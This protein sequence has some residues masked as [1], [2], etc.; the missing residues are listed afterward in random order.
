MNLKTTHPSYPMPRHLKSLVRH[1]SKRAMPQHT[2]SV[3]RPGLW[4]D[5]QLLVPRHGHN[6]LK[7]ISRRPTQ[8]KLSGSRSER[9][10]RRLRPTFGY[11]SQD[12]CTRKRNRKKWHRYVLLVIAPCFVPF[13][14]FLGFSVILCQGVS[15]RHNHTSCSWHSA[16]VGTDSMA[17]TTSLQQSVDMVSLALAIC[18]DSDSFPLNSDYEHG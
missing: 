17:E 18:I 12:G 15:G 4:V 13:C 3:R 14:A 1:K 5:R 10:Q 2:D 9:K 11:Q 7:R 16:R 8:F 6:P